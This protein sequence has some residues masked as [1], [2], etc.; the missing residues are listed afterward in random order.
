[1]HY[2]KV[3]DFDN[4]HKWRIILVNELNCFYT[5]INRWRYAILLYV[6][7]GLYP[8]GNRNEQWN[9]KWNGRE[10]VINVTMMLLKKKERDKNEQIVEKG[11]ERMEV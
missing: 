2:G 5:L 1:M 8:C 6:H 4:C 9:K 7:V 3:S 10:N 11:T